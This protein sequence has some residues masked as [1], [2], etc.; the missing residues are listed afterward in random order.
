MNIEKLK[1]GEINNLSNLEHPI[2]AIKDKKIEKELKEFLGVRRNVKDIFGKILSQLG[3][4]SDDIIYLKDISCDNFDNKVIFE[5]SVNFVNDSSNKIILNFG[6]LESLYSL[7]IIDKNNVVKCG[8]SVSKKDIRLKI[9]RIEERLDNG[10]VYTRSYDWSDSDY[11]INLGNRKIRLHLNKKNDNNYQR[12][13]VIEN[14]LKL[15]EY[16]KNVDESISIDNLYKDIASYLG[17]VSEYSFVTLS[18]GSVLEDKNKTEV[19]DFIAIRNGVCCEFGITRGNKKIVLKDN[20]SWE[21]S[22]SDE[23]YSISS[24]GDDNRVTYSVSANDKNSLRE[25]AV[26]SDLDFDILT[27]EVEDTKKLVREMFPKKR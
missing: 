22:Y 26:W 21:Y 18:M 19:T 16:L 4:K 23:L 8:C 12:L 1:L 17:E 2:I 11:I 6:D 14:E 10:R 13:M 15:E 5:Y 24:I 3:F 7:I 27:E 9:N 20:D 25:C